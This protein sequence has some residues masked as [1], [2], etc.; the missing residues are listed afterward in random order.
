MIDVTRLEALGELYCW[1]IGSTHLGTYTC[2]I[3]ERAK[4]RDKGRVVINSCG[5]TYQD[6][7]DVALKDFD[8]KVLQLAK[9]VA[10]FAH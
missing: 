1:T 3:W 10:Q 4:W 2:S 9:V 7:I 8:S 5:Q 6:A